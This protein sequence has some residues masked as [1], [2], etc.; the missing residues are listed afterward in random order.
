MKKLLLVVGLVVSSIVTVRAQVALVNVGHITNSGFNL[1]VTAITVSGNYAYL[2]TVGDNLRIYDVSN[3]SAPALVSSITNS[4]TAMCIAASGNYAYTANYSAL[5]I[6]DVSNPAN[7]TNIGYTTTPYSES[8]AASGNYAYVGLNSQGLRIYDVSNPIGPSLVGQINNSFPT[9]S[10]GQ[11]IGIAVSGHY[12]YL[13]NGGDGFRIYDVS[14]PAHPINVGYVSDYNF[15]FGTATGVAVA[16][17]YAF[18]ANSGDGLRIYDVTNP[19]IPINVGY[20]NSGVGDA[21]RVAVGG[22]L[23][24]VSFRTDGARI[25][26]VSNPANPTE[27]GS[28][29]GVANEVAVSGN[30]AYVAAGGDGVNIYSLLPQLSISRIRTTNQ[31]VVYGI[32]P[33]GS[34]NIQYGYIT[35]NIISTNLKLSWPALAAT[36][37]PQATSDLTTTNWMTLTNTPSMVGGQRQVILPLPTANQFYRLMSP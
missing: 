16:G 19:A 9:P 27:V 6:Y 5:N 13:A 25:Y 29:G 7:A 33:N 15:T 8:V 22:N 34:N 14:N 23:A 24:Y 1:G 20:A 17:H 4:G 35:N 21:W 28:I 3:P 32:I 12:V 10:T 37:L 11:A 26:D 31:V 30:Y 2:S 18:L 36:F